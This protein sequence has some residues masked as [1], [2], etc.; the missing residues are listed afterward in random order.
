MGVAAE[1]LKRFALGRSSDEGAA[2]QSEQLGKTDAVRPKGCLIWVISETAAEAGPSAALSQALAQRLDQVVYTLVTPLD[3]TPLAPA[4]DKEVIH[5]FAPI[6]TEGTI[7]RFLDHWQPEVCLVLGNP[8]RPKL[9]AAAAR[10]GIPLLHAATDR[11]I[12][13]VPRRH[14]AYLP[15]F[16]TSFAPSAAEANAL[17]LGLSGTETNV[18][19][20][21][22]LTDTAYALPCNEAECDDLSKLLGG[23]PVWLASE[24][25]AAEITVVEAAHRKAFRSAHRLLL[26]IVPKLGLDTDAIVRQLENSGWRVAQRSN[27]DEPDPEIQIYLADTEEELGLWYRLAPASFIGGSIQSDVEPTDPFAP[28]ALGSAVLCGPNKGKNPARFEA[29]AA[30]G[31]CVEVNSAE[32]LGA[33]VITLLAPDKAASLAQAGWATTTESAHVVERIAEVMEGLLTEAEDGT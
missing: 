30:Q 23:R 32:E 21:G 12:D 1:R 28:A 19:I 17:R 11:P 5:Q 20:T 2:R 31:A 18:E 4:L 15:L 9:F 7:Q 8:Q 26:I 29:L 16:H 10:R 25:D 13:P 6:D 33:A 22:P 27:L 14:P 3:E 24:V